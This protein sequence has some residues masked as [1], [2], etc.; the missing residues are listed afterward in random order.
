ME[1]VQTRQLQLEKTFQLFCRHMHVSSCVRELWIWA[2]LKHLVFSLSVFTLSSLFWDPAAAEDLSAPHV[3][4][5]LF[6]FM[7]PDSNVQNLRWNISHAAT[8]R[9]IYKFRTWRKTKACEC[10]TCFKG[11]QTENQSNNKPLIQNSDRLVIAREIAINVVQYL[12]L[13]IKKKSFFIENN[14][15]THFS[16]MWCKDLYLRID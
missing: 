5:E 7:A 3:L 1:R 10:C 2:A 16:G 8:V 12:Y 6:F 11:A 14:A 9:N 15:L 13:L 4:S